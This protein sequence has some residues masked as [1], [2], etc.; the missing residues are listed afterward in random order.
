MLPASTIGGYVL[1]EVLA[2]LLADNGYSLLT[3]A[4]QDP[5]YLLNDRHGLLVRG[6]GTNHQADALGNLAVLVP[7][8]LP[9]RLFAEAKNRASKTGLEAV[10]NA[11]G[12]VA[13]VNQYQPASGVVR[14]WRGDSTYHY[15][16]S[17]FSTSG[18][19]TPAQDFAIAHQISLID[20]SGPSFASL[21]RLVD[22]FAAAVEALAL[23]TS[24]A[25]FP[26]GQ[27]RAALRTAL[28]TDPTGTSSPDPS[29]GE[30]P[31]LP[32]RDLALLTQELAD[33]LDDDLVLGFPAG[34]QVLALR[35]DVPA[36]FRNWAATAPPVVPVT[37]RFAPGLPRGEWTIRPVSDAWEPRVVLRFGTPPALAQWLFAP[38]V[39]ESERLDLLRRGVLSTIRIY[40]D[41]RSIELQL[42]VDFRPRRDQM[43]REEILDSLRRE[44]L[45]EDLAWPSDQLE[46]SE[47]SPVWPPGAVSRYLELL[48]VQDPARLSVLLYAAGHGGWI[49]RAHVYELMHFD[50]SRKLSGFTKPFDRVLATVAAEGLLEHPVSRPI[51]AKYRGSN[52]WA[53]GFEVDRGFLRVLRS[54]HADLVL[55]EPQLES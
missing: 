18:F 41:G 19:T 4:Q 49:S 53:L 33:T 3:N 25:T 44:R 28:R 14:T 45:E 2:K 24:L 9:V 40:Q 6:R 46:E 52:G 8:S 38:E 36:A 31:Y 26:V 48:G 35:P 12:V 43:P 20:L 42:D 10:R 50:V 15:R 54:N 11:A 22:N 29:T 30:L 17:L 7:F 21:R 39:D 27:M 47:G 32:A 51:Q 34:P 16:Y 37:L 1:E 55:D 23:A 5:R 13:D